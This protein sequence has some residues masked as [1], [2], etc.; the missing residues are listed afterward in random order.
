MFTA[1]KAAGKL[2]PDDDE[3][4]FPYS[5]EYVFKVFWDLH[6]VRGSNG[7][8]MNPISYHDIECYMRVMSVELVPW[9]VRL[10]RIMDDVMLKASRVASTKDTKAAT[11]KK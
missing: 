1:I 6:Q 5:R 4:I 11:T 2:K 3:P 8:S 7:F 9:D 10:I